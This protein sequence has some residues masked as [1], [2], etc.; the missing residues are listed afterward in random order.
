[1]ARQLEPSL[2]AQFK[3]QEVRYFHFR[4]GPGQ[5]IVL[6]ADAW[7][8]LQAWLTQRV[9]EHRGAI[10]RRLERAL[11]YSELAESFYRAADQVTLPARGT[12]AYYGM[13][14]LVKCFISVRGTELETTLEHHGLSLPLGVH[15]TIEVR[16]PGRD[17][18]SI[19]GEL[20]AALGTPLRAQHRVSFN[21]AAS[22]IPE[23]HEIAYVL[24]HLPNERRKFLPIEINLRV[25]Q[26]K[27]HLFAEV[28]YEKKNQ[29][30]LQ[31]DKFFRGPRERYFREPSEDAGR[32]TYRS[33]RRRAV[34]ADNWPRVYR[35]I[36]DELSAFDV[37]SLLTRSGYC[38]Y[39]DLAPGPFHH[40]CYSLMTMFYI[41]TIARYRPTETSG[42]MASDLRPLVAEIV[43]ACPNQFLY[44]IVSHT[45]G[46]VVVIPYA[47]LT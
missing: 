22:H 15:R 23:I 39:C 19:F 28:R 17:S 37:A 30:R 12:L 35:R 4:V 45:T 20:A 33:R 11:Y 5:A 24:G 6:A 1:M 8:F 9:K 14:N 25:N 13:L 7:S 36:C 31:C 46:N 21:E 47:K 32:I 26:A 3:Y 18:I 16:G 43:A 40:L 34:S 42:L 41:G 2:P 10:R 38:F 29:A 44:Q 27:S